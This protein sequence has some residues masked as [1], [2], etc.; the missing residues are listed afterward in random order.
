MK[1]LNATW[2]K[3]N[4]NYQQEVLKLEIYRNARLSIERELEGCRSLLD[5]GNGGFF[6]YDISKIQQVVA[7]DLFIDEENP[8]S[9]V[10]FV[11]A[12]AMEFQIDRTFDRIIMQNVIHHIPGLSPDE[13][14]RNLHALMASCRRHL[15][16]DGRLIVVESTVPRWFNIFE[17]MVFQALL[18]MWCFSHPLTFQH[19]ASDLR[20]SALRTGF[21]VLD[22]TII[23][24]GPYVLQFGIKVPSFTTPVQLLKIVLAPA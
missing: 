9:N 16:K 3:G 1:D 8:P 2:F 14:V 22:Y 17:R 24:K 13:A 11:Q 12:D 23:P 18:K 20:T 10:E 15:A 7:L 19:T 6:N 21:K 4:H 5:I